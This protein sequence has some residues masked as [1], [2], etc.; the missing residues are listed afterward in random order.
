MTGPP[1]LVKPLHAAWVTPNAGRDHCQPASR[2]ACQ[3]ADIVRKAYYQP[4]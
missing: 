1:V 3:L 4:W 2:P